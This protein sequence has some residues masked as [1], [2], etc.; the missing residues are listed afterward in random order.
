MSPLPLCHRSPYAHAKVALLVFDDDESPA[1]SGDRSP[2]SKVLRAGIWVA[3]AVRVFVAPLAR[4]YG[5]QRD[6]FHLN[7]APSS[8]FSG[9]EVGEF[10]C[11]N[12]RYVLRLA[13]PRS[14][15][16][17]CAIGCEM[18]VSWCAI[19]SPV[20][21]FEGRGG[22]GDSSGFL[23][24]SAILVQFYPVEQASLKS[25]SPRVSRHK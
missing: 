2:H 23:S 20:A 25:L 3:R 15:E 11:K 13:E 12:T 24:K 22:L 7:S 10:E 14:A 16:S 18:A 21:Q 5:S 9:R 4:R 8:K 6:P 17:G 19:V 1:E